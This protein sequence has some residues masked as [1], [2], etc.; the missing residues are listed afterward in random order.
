[1]PYMSAQEV[2]DGLRMLRETG[3]AYS[4]NS[5]LSVDAERELLE[6]LKESAQ[7]TKKADSG[8]E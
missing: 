1:M 7:A 3:T 5:Q 8:D 2:I 4:D 6:V